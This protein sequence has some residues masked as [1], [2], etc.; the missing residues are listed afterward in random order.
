MLLRR[1]KIQNTGF[2]LLEM[3]VVL[4]VMGLAMA[5]IAGYGQPRSRWLETQS[6]AREIAAAMRDARGQAIAQGHK[7]ALS[8]PNLPSW[9][10]VT[11]AA[12]PGGIVFAPDGSASGGEVLLNGAGHHTAITADWLTGQVAIHGS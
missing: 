2:T 3:M 9:L 4:A 11:M 5:L 10:R 7:V 8:L 12:P 1:P 6:A